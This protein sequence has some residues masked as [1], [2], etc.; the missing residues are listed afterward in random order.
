MAS[1]FIA[2]SKSIA[3][4]TNCVFTFM[5]VDPVWY[6]TLSNVMHV[7]GSSRSFHVFVP[8][9]RDKKYEKSR[10]RNQQVNETY[11]LYL[12][13]HF[14]WASFSLSLVDF[15]ACWIRLLARSASN[16]VDL[17]NFDSLAL[18]FCMYSRLLAKFFSF[19]SWS[20]LWYLSRSLSNLSRI[21]S[22]DSAFLKWF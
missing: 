15:S 21:C 2:K 3:M 16:L 8:R 11:F 1:R 17:L 6:I 13:F 7:H 19:A 9:K 10:I 18:S 22:E 4:G 14:A 20:K 5:D 12:C